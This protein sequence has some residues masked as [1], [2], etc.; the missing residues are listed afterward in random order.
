M[1]FWSDVGDF[2]EDA[3]N[4]AIEAVEIAGDV[5]EVAGP[6]VTAVNPG[7]GMAMMQFAQYERMAEPYLEKAQAEL[8]DD[9]APKNAQ[10]QQAPQGDFRHAEINEQAVQDFFANSGGLEIT[11]DESLEELLAKIFGKQINDKTAELKSLANSGGEKT[12]AENLDIQAK[13]FELQT[14]VAAGSKLVSTAGETRTTA[15]GRTN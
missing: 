12:A 7:V 8:N 3:A 10:A 5:C 15:L 2:C 4:V 11:G 13:A 14:L 1:S 9:E 6:V